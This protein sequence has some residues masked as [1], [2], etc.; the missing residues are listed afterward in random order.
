VQMRLEAACR[1]A[2]FLP[3]D[4]AQCRCP[5]ADAAALLADAMPEVSAALAGPG[6]CH[7]WD[8]VLRWHPEAVLA[9]RRAEIAGAGRE[10]LAASV[11]AALARER[12]MREAGLRAALGRV[13]LAVASA[14]GAV[15]TEAGLT[16]LLPAHGEAA[17]EQALSALPPE[18][19]DGA[20]ADLRGPLPAVSFSAVRVVSAAPGEVA[21][22][23]QALALPD[24]IDAD[25]LRRHWR[26][27]AARVHPDHGIA[28]D[29]PMVAA[30]AAFRLLRSL[31]PAGAPAQAWTL[32]A[33]QRRSA[34]MLQVPAL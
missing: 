21:Q 17:L 7:Q 5:A 19:S 10:E 6:R 23:W 25:G 15:E 13:S 28:E 34:R 29:G 24:W 27:C 2:P 3:A 12:A 16:V 1:V 4:P 31:L 8:V 9:R 22:A 26:E 32:A 33:L 30:G 20:S 18:I 11:A 14:A